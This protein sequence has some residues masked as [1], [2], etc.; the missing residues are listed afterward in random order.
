MAQIAIGFKPI[1][2]KP[3]QTSTGPGLRDIEPRMAQTSHEEEEMG[4]PPTQRM[5]Q[6]SRA[7]SHLLIVLTTRSCTA[8]ASSTEQSPYT[9]P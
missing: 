8:L 9:R 7:R 3:Q 1:T 2:D 6:V 4:I 5:S